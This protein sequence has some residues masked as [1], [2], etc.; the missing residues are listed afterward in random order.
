MGIISHS[1]EMKEKRALELGWTPEAS[2]IDEDDFLINDEDIRILDVEGHNW[3][4]DPK[5]AR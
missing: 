2:K 4:K 3:Q 1:F 5:Y